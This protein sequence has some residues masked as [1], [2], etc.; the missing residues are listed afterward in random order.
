MTHFILITWRVPI[1]KRF[2]STM[3]F[4]S[5]NMARL[6]AHLFSRW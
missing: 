5:H 3:V 6:L 1:G 2:W 4:F